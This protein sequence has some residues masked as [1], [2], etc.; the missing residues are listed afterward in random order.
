[1]LIDHQEQPGQTHYENGHSQGDDR[2]P[3]PQDTLLFMTMGAVLMIDQ[4]SKWF[5]RHNLNLYELW[6]AQGAVRLTH[7][8]NS[9]AALSLF[10]DYLPAVIAFSVIS[11][12]LYM[13]VYQLQ[14]SAGRLGR[15]AAGLAVGG[16]LGNLIDRIANGTVTDF[17]SVGLFPVFNIADIAIFAGIGLMVMPMLSAGKK[18]ASDETVHVGLHF[19]R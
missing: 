19:E 8:E 10:P 14:S 4:V 12:A 15:L 6:P 13:Y 5:V 9:G 16:T 1:M 11:I 3:W 7:T 2:T 18:K 17:V